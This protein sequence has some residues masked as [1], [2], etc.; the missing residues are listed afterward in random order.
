MCDYSLEGYKARAAQ[1]G[2]TLVVGYTHGFMEQTTH[3]QLNAKLQRAEPTGHDDMCL[4]CLK[5]GTRLDV[6]INRRD[7]TNVE[8]R[9]INNA[10][11]GFRDHLV[12]GERCTAIAELPRGTT[13]KVLSIPGVQSLDEKLGLDQIRAEVPVAPA[14]QR[15]TPVYRFW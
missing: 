1:V 12:I 5:P 3:E 4:T 8:F 10:A 11:T 14:R 13:A 6:T 9:Q 7:Y 15:L 2:D